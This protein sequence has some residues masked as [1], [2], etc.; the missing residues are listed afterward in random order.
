MHFMMCNSKDFFPTAISRLYWYTVCFFSFVIFYDD[1]TLKVVEII[2][3]CKKFLKGMVD[4]FYVIQLPGLFYQNLILWTYL[5]Q[6]VIISK[7]SFCKNLSN[8]LF[9]FKWHSFLNGLSYWHQIGLRWKI[10]W[11]S[12]W[13]NISWKAHVMFLMIVRTMNQLLIKI[14]IEKQIFLTPNVAYY[15]KKVFLIVFLKTT[16]N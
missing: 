10:F 3:F 13:E 6:D 7:L 1:V 9:T 12:F 8:G 4:A 16:I 15:Q 11:S 14:L 5:E 2:D